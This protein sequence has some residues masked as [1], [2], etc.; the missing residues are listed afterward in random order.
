M[1]G[2]E[3]PINELL[4][5]ESNEDYN[6]P[7]PIYQSNQSSLFHNCRVTHKS[8]VRG[9]PFSCRV[10][11]IYPNRGKITSIYINGVK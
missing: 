7:V 9:K 11:D 2:T 10:N 4:E 3:T 5:L 6:I 8:H 1:A